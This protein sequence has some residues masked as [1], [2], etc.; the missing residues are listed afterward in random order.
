[1]CLHQESTGDVA[2]AQ[3]SEGVRVVVTVRPPL[4]LR[5]LW[6]HVLSHFIAFKTALRTCVVLFSQSFPLLMSLVH[7]SSRSPA[8]YFRMRRPL[9]EVHTY[10]FKTDIRIARQH[11]HYGWR[12][13]TLDHFISVR[14][15]TQLQTSR[16]LADT[17]NRPSKLGWAWLCADAGFQSN[18][19]LSGI[20]STG[21]TA[22]AH[23]NSYVT[24]CV[25]QMTHTIPSPRIRSGSP[26]TWT[27]PVQCT[28]T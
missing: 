25:A 16:S 10:R 17:F 12:A 15:G 8:S 24:S 26:H 14:C 9:S 11:S 13:S 20:K 6:H 22:S 4:P 2:G 23:T 18:L 5:Q 19:S 1:M 3:A 27:P 21:G 28:S 7:V